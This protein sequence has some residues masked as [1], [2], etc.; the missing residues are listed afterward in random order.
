M[1]LPLFFARRYLFARKSHNVINIISV[2]SAVGMAFGTAALIIILS[3]FNGFNDL[4]KKSLG[5]LNPDFLVES[6]TG[7]V[8]VPD[9]SLVSKWNDDS[10]IEGVVCVLQDR[11][12]V[13]YDSKQSVAIAKGVEDN[14]EWL[15]LLGEHVVIGQF[16]LHRGEIPQCGVGAGLAGKLGLNPN[17]IAPLELY[18]PARERN[19][20][21][22]NPLASIESESLRPSCT[23]SVSQDVDNSLV[24]LPISVMR[25]LMEYNSGEVSGIEFRTVQGLSSKELRNL[26]KELKASIGSDFILQDRYTQNES[27]YRMMKYEKAFIFLILIFVI[28][29]IAFNIFGCL[30]MLTIEKESDI[31]TLRSMG[32]ED[33][34]IRRIFTLE[35]WLISLLGLTIG[36]VIGVGFVLLQQHFGF[37]KMPGSFI[38]SA[39]P[40]VLQFGDVVLTSVGVAVIGYI[41]ALIPSRRI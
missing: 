13:S 32:A 21:L 22:S 36:L 26:E 31:A 3:V 37:I 34:L 4:V 2:I 19:I 30:T 7:R 1:N 28:I 11:V 15:S 40:T 29:I 16:R 27:I 41:I 8:F 9:S 12:F 5:D 38:V 18:Y 24:V 20:S 23:F 17:F 33:N 6:R 35:G 25:S 39:Y 14:F 10:R